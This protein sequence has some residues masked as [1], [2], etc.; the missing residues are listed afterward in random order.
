MAISLALSFGCSSQVVR[1]SQALGCKPQNCEG[2]CL[3]D[4][5]DIQPKPISSYSLVLTIF[6]TTRIK[7]KSFSVL[8]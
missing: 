8:P 1:R 2:N 3:L 4:L 7:F 6:T 5:V